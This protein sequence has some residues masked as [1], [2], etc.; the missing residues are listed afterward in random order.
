MRSLSLSLYA[1]PIFLWSV[2]TIFVMV[3]DKRMIILYA[4]ISCDQPLFTLYFSFLLDFT[5]ILLSLSLSLYPFYLSISFTSLSYL[6]LPPSLYLSFYLSF[7]LSI[8]LFGVSY[9]RFR[10]CFLE[11]SKELDIQFL[12]NTF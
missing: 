10:P 2:Y 9:G 1:L 8:I 4:I 3:K 7:S 6:S 11:S 5:R 12:F